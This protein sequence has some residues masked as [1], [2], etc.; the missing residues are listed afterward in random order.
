L[1]N[2]PAAIVKPESNRRDTS[3]SLWFLPVIMAALWIGYRET[4]SVIRRQP[5]D[6]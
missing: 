3:F 5:T 2:Q 6:I 1:T 4:R